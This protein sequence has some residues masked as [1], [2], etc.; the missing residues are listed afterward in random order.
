MFRLTLHVE[1]H[2][3]DFAL[4]QVEGFLEDW[5]FQYGFLEG[6]EGWS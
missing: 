6:Y 4:Q 5:P 3:G 2:M 1:D